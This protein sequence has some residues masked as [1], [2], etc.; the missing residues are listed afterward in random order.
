MKT[1]SSLVA[2]G[3]GWPISAITRPEPPQDQIGALRLW[4]KSQPIDSAMLPE[5]VARLDVVGPLVAGISKRSSL[6][7][8]EIA[9]LSFCN[10]VQ[11]FL[12]LIRG[13]H[14][15]STLLTYYAI[16]PYSKASSFFNPIHGVGTAERQDHGAT[17]LW[18]GAVK[19]PFFGKWN[20]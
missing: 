3:P 7:G 10:P 1:Q 5:P 13:L 2:I 19:P 20:Q 6:L 12:W 15:R 16:I 14:N 18:D 17:T 4:E 9:S 8:R 11:L